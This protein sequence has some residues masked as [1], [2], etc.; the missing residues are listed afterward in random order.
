MIVTK[1]KIQLVIF[2]WAG[3]TIDFGS[4]APATAFTKVFAAHGVQVSDEE[5]R[6]PMGLNKR[7]HIVAML[8]TDEIS[9]RWLASKGV[10]WTDVDVS[11]MYDQFVPYQLEAIEQS[12]ILVPHLLEVIRSLR[13]DEV[14]VG[15]TTGYF[16]AAA[17][18]VSQA[19]SKQGFVPDA[20]VCADDVPNGRPAPWMIYQVM[21]ML[22]VY[23]PQHVVKIG[24]T[25]ADIE[26]GRNAGTWTIGVC[27]SSSILGLSLDDYCGLDAMT[28]AEKLKATASVFQDAGSHFTITS[29][30]ELPRVVGQINQRL[31]AGDR[32]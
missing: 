30:E 25:I 14:K 7:E 19:A 20:N 18:L 8:S 10:P 4:C 17:E 15:S 28:K 27:D 5:A 23:P 12:S 13:A 9:Q 22:N 3:T 2:D 11:L 31:A 1:G 21:Q 16:R 24:D 32:P 6:R 29:I 26:A